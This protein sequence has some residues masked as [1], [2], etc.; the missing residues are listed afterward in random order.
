MKATRITHLKSKA[1]KGKV[2]LTWK[3]TKGYK[4]DGYQIYRSVKKDGVY[5]SIGKTTAKKYTN[6]S[7]LKKGTRYYYKV[8]GYRMMD[9]KIVYTKW[10][11]IVSAKAK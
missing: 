1:S 9:K 11:Q 7:S 8:R 10:S 3:K 4:A 5:R 6:S 2:T